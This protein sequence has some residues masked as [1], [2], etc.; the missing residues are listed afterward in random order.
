MWGPSWLAPVDPPGV[1]GAAL[2]VAVRSRRKTYA[3]ILDPNNNGLVYTTV[4]DADALGGKAIRAPG[5]SHRHLPGTHDT[6]AVYDMTFPTG[7]HLSG[8]LSGQGIQRQLRQP[9]C[10]Q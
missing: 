1:V 4:D 10:S 7:W 5:G 9:L 3:A 6:I 8:L 2:P